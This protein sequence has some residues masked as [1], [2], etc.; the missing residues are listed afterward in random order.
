MELMKAIANRQSCRLYT[1]EQIIESE[2]QTILQAAN[3]APV[4]FGY[5]NEV[6]LTVIQNSELLAKIDAA[7]SALF[8]NPNIKI[9]YN[10]PTLILVS[11]K[12]R[13]S[14]PPVFSSSSAGSEDEPM[15]FQYCNAAC[16]I[17]NMVLAA[18]DLGLGNVYLMGVPA[19]LAANPE[20]CAE[21][22]IPEGF[23]PASALAIGR[24]A[25]PLN[26]RELTL[27]KIATEYFI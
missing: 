19:V 18:T 5:Y 4:A 27:S 24:A 10:A 26:E 23:M 22:K 12:I 14:V 7:G 16:I 11:T 17:E 15:S 25:K 8:G 20:L 2:L 21:L 3:A 13:A 6:K 1:E 9:R